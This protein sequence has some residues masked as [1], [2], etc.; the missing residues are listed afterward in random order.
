MRKGTT[1][2]HPYQWINDWGWKEVSRG[3]AK[4]V[5]LE[6][7]NEYARLLGSEFIV[8]DKDADEMPGPD[9]IGD[10][11]YGYINRNTEGTTTSSDSG[12]TGADK[13]TTSDVP[14]KRSS[15]SKRTGKTT[16]AKPTGTTAAEDS[17]T[18]AASID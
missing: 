8:W 13:P 15:S 17:S 11:H 5:L 6:K 4:D 2:K 7:E 12:A 18:T 16:S 10:K 3:S 1:H 14:R 9:I